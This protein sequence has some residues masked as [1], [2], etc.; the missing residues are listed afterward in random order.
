MIGLSETYSNVTAFTAVDIT[1]GAV[2]TEGTISNVAEGK[3]TV[4]VVLADDLLVRLADFDGSLILL[5]TGGGS[6]GS[7][8][9][10]EGNEDELHFEGG[11][12]CSEN[13]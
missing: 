10:S 6:E 7:D 4:A 1:A 9:E 11:K 8:G 2:V 3:E 12:G 5:A 13:K